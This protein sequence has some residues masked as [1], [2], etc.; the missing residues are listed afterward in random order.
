MKNKLIIYL[1]VLLAIAAVLLVMA[2]YIRILPFELMLSYTPLFGFLTLAGLLSATVALIRN[3]SLRSN[4]WLIA[5]ASIGLIASICALYAA[6]SFQSP[7]ETSA[8]GRG[9]IAFATFN[10]LY[11]NTDLARAADYFRQERVD[12]IAFQETRPEEVTKLKQLLGFEHS[13]NSEALKTARG[14]VVGIISRW[15]IKDAAL[16]T[17]SNGPPLIRTVVTVPGGRDMAFYGVHLPGPF[18]LDLYR[19]RNA[20]IVSV[21][22]ALREDS[23]PATLGGDFNSTVYSPA[24]REF[25]E[26]VAVKA[27]PTITEQLPQ[28]SWYGLGAPL[29]A[30][31]DHIYIPKYATLVQTTIAPDLGSDHRAVM[32]RFT[33]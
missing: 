24:L 29:C 5:A 6:S 25:N 19:Q 28:C 31:I 1:V 9:T 7:M 21:A 13:F 17:L 14:T 3:K 32:V 15:P 10:K 27:K 30:R 26:L 18:S 11:S 8:A 22:R 33:L 20:N 12:V 16:N 23:L 4:R 2:L